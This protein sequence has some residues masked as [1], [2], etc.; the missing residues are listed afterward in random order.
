MEYIFQINEEQRQIIVSA[1]STH[2]ELDF[3][4]R[5]EAHLL[6]RMFHD[7]PAREDEMRA[8]GILE[9]VHGFTL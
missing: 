1:L 3:T 7:L 5:N 9:G 8:N 4:K 2:L 6:E